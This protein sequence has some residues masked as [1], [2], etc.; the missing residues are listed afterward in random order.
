[1]TV[2]SYQLKGHRP[3]FGTKKVVVA[4]N[5]FKNRR[6]NVFNQSRASFLSYLANGLK[7][8]FWL[9]GLLIFFVFLF[10]FFVPYLVSLDYS[11]SQLKQE[12]K[13]AEEQNAALRESLAKAIDINTLNSWV[14]SHGFVAIDK[15]SYLDLNP[16]S[17]LAQLDVHQR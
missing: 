9:I 8:H 14:S 5:T 4:S 11:I 2:I 15:V 10:A 7:F 3:L 1:M 13:V 16:Q 6:Q 12:I 17:N